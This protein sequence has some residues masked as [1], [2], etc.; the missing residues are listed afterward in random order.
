MGRPWRSVSSAW[1]V[2]ALADLADEEVF[3][4]QRLVVE[5]VPVPGSTRGF[6]RGGGPA[7]T[8]VVNVPALG[9]LGATSFQAASP[10]RPWGLLA[11]VAIGALWVLRLLVVGT[12]RRRQPS[13]R[14]E[15]RAPGAPESD[16][17]NLIAQ[18]VGVAVVR[19]VAET[20][21]LDPAQ[22]GTLAGHVVAEIMT[23]LDHLQFDEAVSS[24]DGIQADVR[25]VTSGETRLGGA[26]SNVE[27]SASIIPR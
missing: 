23:A 16:A 2:A 3:V 7:H 27:S 6:A 18:D 17:R 26:R 20:V 15:R 4:E 25:S 10:T 8:D 24:P 12:S 22:I 11:L 14:R 5:S 13:A 1:F 21:D 19:A 9:G